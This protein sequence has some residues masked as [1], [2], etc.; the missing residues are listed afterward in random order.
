MV[1]KSPPLLC[2]LHAH[3]TW[4][5]GA[6]SPA[7]LVDLYGRAGFDVLAIT[8]HTTRDGAHVDAA[9]FADYLS[10]VEAAA[11][12][13]RSRYGMLVIPGLEL[14]YDDANPLRAGHAVAVGLREFVGVADGLDE[15]LAAARGHGAAL[16]AAHPNHPESLGPPGGHG[17]TARFAAEWRELRGAVD[18]FE[19]VN[20]HESFAWVSAAG[21]P[22]VANGDFHRPEHLATWK[23]MLPC[24]K[25]EDAVVAYLRSQRPAYLVRIEA[26]DR[27]AAA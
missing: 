19:L 16:I 12:I 2:E 13:A 1:V 4:S 22:A 18:R 5:D 7:Q 3:T 21:L 24:A 27:A 25:T 10:A 20:R 9:R 6:L 23:T 26:V 14:T 15:A 8:D 11:A 17:R